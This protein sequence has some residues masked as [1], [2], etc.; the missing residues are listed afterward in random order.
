MRIVEFD[1]V[2]GNKIYIFISHIS[3]ITQRDKGEG[4]RIYIDSSDHPFYVTEDV[5]TALRKIK[6][7]MTQTSK[8]D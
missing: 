4:T 1:G 7:S 8:E 2:N 6:E 5:E 3:S